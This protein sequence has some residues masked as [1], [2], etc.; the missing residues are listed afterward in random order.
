[1]A[2]VKVVNYADR[3][4]V[5]VSKVYDTVHKT[6]LGLAPLLLPRVLPSVIFLHLDL[7]LALLLRAGAS[8]PLPPGGLSSSGSGS[9]RRTA[10]RLSSLT[11]TTGLACVD[12]APKVRY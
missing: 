4:A 11:I 10:E 2:A 6:R 1:M 3:Q 7:D 12:V 8:S 5:S 9:D